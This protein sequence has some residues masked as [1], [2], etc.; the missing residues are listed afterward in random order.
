M[1]WGC[2]EVTDFQVTLVIAGTDEHQSAHQ[3]AWRIFDQ[4]IQQ[5]D[6][7]RFL[8]EEQDLRVLGEAFRAYLQA[9]IFWHQTS[10]VHTKAEHSTI[11]RHFFEVIATTKL[12]RISSGPGEFHDLQ[13]TLIHRAAFQEAFEQLPSDLFRGEGKNPPE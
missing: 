2:L 1:P 10:D 13:V 5:V 11:Q 6:R 8:L 3:S 9:R 7:A 4:T 12:R